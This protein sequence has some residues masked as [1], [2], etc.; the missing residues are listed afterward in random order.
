MVLQFVALLLAPCLC[1][2]WKR[3]L[4]DS[5]EVEFLEVFQQM[6]HF[7]ALPQAAHLLHTLLDPQVCGSRVLLDVFGTK[8]KHNTRPSQSGLLQPEPK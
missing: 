2:W 6:A 8:L 4:L 1:G 7:E 3:L 5:T